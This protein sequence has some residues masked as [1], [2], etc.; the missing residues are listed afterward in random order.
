M[1]LPRSVW[2]SLFAL[3][4]ATIGMG[5]V[6]PILR[7]LS[8][9]FDAS[10]A[11]T[12]LLV[13]VYMVCL[14]AAMPF[15]SAVSSRLGVRR[16]LVGALLLNVVCGVVSSLAGDIGVVICARAGWGLG[17]AL[18]LA[19]VLAVVIEEAGALSGRAIRYFEAA[20]GI[21]ISAGPLA[22]GVL[23]AISWRAAFLGSATMMLV[24]AVSLMILLP[25]A[26][27]GPLATGV[28][29]PFRALLQPGL[30]VLGLASLLYNVGFLM[31]FTFTPFPLARG[32]EF[33]GLVYCGW[34]LA[35]VFSSTFVGP[36]V[37]R[38]IGTLA[39]FTVGTTGFAVVLVVMAVFADRD[40]V[41]VAGVISSGLA[42]GVSNT[43]MTEA[44]MASS[45]TDH[46]TTSAAYN[47]MRNAGPAAAP[48]LAGTL[49]ESLNVHAPF[50]FGAISAIVA[51]VLVLALMGR[52]VVAPVVSRV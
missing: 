14:G 33:V 9:A 52:E 13:S 24:A 1:T 39:S 23:G 27:R 28:F 37:Q 5:L 19:T 45:S 2:A 43:M 25:R 31:M 11:Q 8:V 49:G 15:T 6:V 18:F 47:L 22:G 51:V 20:V 30:L 16:T 42:L 21:G 17:N 40:A 34:G 50:L 4:A 46:T 48:W 29:A 44:A 35:L 41:L 12:L 3:V 32:P 26:E 10:P 38:R 7:P 36:R